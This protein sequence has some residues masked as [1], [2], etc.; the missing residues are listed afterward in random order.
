MNIEAEL[1]LLS[2]LCSYEEVRAKIPFKLD[3]SDFQT[4]KH[5]KIY[6]VISHIRSNGNLSKLSLDVLLSTAKE[7]GITDF[8]I[9]TNDGKYL[10]DLLDKQLNQDE[11]LTFANQVKRESIKSKILT[12]LKKLEHY[13]S[14][15]PDKLKDILK[16]CEDTIFSITTSGD[17]IENKPSKLAEKVRTHIDFL[18]NNPGLAGLDIGFPE[19]QSRIG[20]ICNGMVHMVIATNKS[21]KSTLGGRAAVVLGQHIPVLI[22]DTEMS[23][24]LQIERL[25]CTFIKLPYN[26]LKNGFWNDPG[27]PDYK[28]NARIQQGIKDFEKTFKIE[29]L[30]ASGKSVLD[31]IPAM[32]RWTIENKTSSDTKFPRGLIVYDYLKLNSFEE[33]GKFGIAEFQ[34]LGLDAAALKDF[35]N[36]YR[37]PILTFGQTNRKDDM[38]IDC[39]GASK[40]LADLCDSVTLFKEKTPELRTADPD[41]SHLLRVFVSRHGPSTSYGEHIRVDFDKSCGQL[42]EKGLYTPSA[43]SPIAKKR[44]FKKYN[45]TTDE[46]LESDMNDDGYDQE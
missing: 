42:Q 21:G 5:K 45:A 10:T 25:F 24:E 23:E 22:V 8:T 46:I 17:H 7:L 9:V 31:M 19:W 16:Q 13:V 20:G 35:A 12:N 27:H 3:E 32:R 34:K 15:S 40:R 14:E 4:I 33:L 41:A 1:C 11:I 2:G 36:K 26:I 28:Y 44:N 39:L 37:I 6:S 18:G 29:Y 30:N 43:S 38:T